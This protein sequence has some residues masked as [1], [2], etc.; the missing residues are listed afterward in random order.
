VT[1][2]ELAGPPYRD[3]RRACR[4]G[5]AAA[6]RLGVAGGDIVE[7]VDPLGAPV[8]A[9]ID[10]IAEDAGDI[11]WLTAEVLP[12]LT[13]AAPEVEVRRASARRPG[14]PPRA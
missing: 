4:L 14:A 11:A 13:R 5:A 12:L 3:A 1:L 7:F 10:G 9:W 2:H 6:A 8:R